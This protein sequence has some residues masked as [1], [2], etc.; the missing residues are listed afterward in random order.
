MSDP[1]FGSIYLGGP[2]T[3]LSTAEAF[4]WREDATEI[5]TALGYDV[6]SPM[7]GKGSLQEEYGD[8]PLTIST[9]T[10]HILKMPYFVRDMYDIDQSGIVIFNFQFMD[11]P[12]VGSLVELGHAH[13]QGKLIIVVLPVVGEAPEYMAHGG[14]Y[15]QFIEKAA[16]VVV[17]SLEDAY[18]V[19]YHLTPTPGGSVLKIA[20]AKFTLDD[21]EGDMLA[22]ARMDDD[23]NE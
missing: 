1:L 5:L 18:D 21:F 4:G 2:I 10:E 7:R 20:E 16:S 14:E 3:G 19:C 11:K 9:N 6:R 23:D 15:H 17:N 8:E 13:G 12:S 22:W